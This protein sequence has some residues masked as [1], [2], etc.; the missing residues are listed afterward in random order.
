MDWF[1][2]HTLNFVTIVVRITLAVLIG[3]VIGLER[4]MKNHTAGFRTHIL[5]CLGA[6]L[7]MMTNLY[8]YQTYGTSD[9]TRMGAQVISG[10][11]FLGA[12]TILVT[13][14]NQI[15]G[16]TTAAGLWTAATVGLALGIGFYEG[17]FATA[18]A[19]LLIMTVFQ[20][21]KKTIEMK[22]LGVD[23]HIT[24]INHDCFKEFLVYCAQR[25][26]LVKHIERIESKPYFDHAVSY[27]MTIDVNDAKAHIA[28]VKDVA[29]IEGVLEVQEL[30]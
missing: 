6:T 28:F 22:S 16:L 27:M 4:S 26:W 17:A 29:L 2:L 21:L 24:F 5:V 18:I 23:C 20:R 19:I 14:Y 9:P 3:G 10:I 30:S 15:K 25:T 8:I 13:R 11:G 1:D 7:V 12:G